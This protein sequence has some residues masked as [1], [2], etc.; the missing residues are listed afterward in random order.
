MKWV[1]F[2][3][4][5]LAVYYYFEKSSDNIQFLTKQ[6][7]ID[8]FQS[9]KDGYIQ[10]MTHYDVLAMKSKTKEEYL[11]KSCQDADD[12][13]EDEKKFLIKVCN[14]VDN[15][16]RYKMK[17]IPYINNKKL[18]DMKWILSKTRGDWYEGGYPH[19]RLDMI[20]INTQVIN[21]RQLERTMI[22]EKIHVY[23]RM[24]PHDMERWIKFMGYKPYKR[25]NEY[26]YARANPD[27]D[28]WV[29]IDPLGNETL[30]L[31][32]TETPKGIDDSD[33]PGGMNYMAE[34]PNETLAYYVDH[35]YEN[36]T[37][38]Y[39]KLIAKLNS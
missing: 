9:D 36:E 15:F 13:T 35:L 30:A 37:F 25:F 26:K 6:E 17:K 2:F 12:F 23:E 28:G 24:F 5:I 8:F 10:N 21:F 14:K 22:H 4:V 7:T 39:P 38:P 3:L 32:N 18:A 29:Y 27:L 20:F 31:F 19:T 1:I 16:I 11:E 34:H 33:Y